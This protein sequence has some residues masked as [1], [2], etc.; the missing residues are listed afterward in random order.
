MTIGTRTGTALLTGLLAATLAACG[1]D[2]GGESNDFADQSIDKIKEQVLADMHDAK[3]LTLKGS[4]SSDS[5]E[6]SLELSADT[7]GNCTGSVSAGEGTADFI[8]A[9]DA[10]FIKADEAFWR[11][12]AGASADAVLKVIGEKWAKLPAGVNQ[13]AE[14]C[15]RDTFIKE[16]EDDNE[17]DEKA[18]KGD[19]TEVDGQQALEI[20]SDED[21]DTTH[22]WVATEGK[23]YI[24]KLESE[25]D[26]PGEFTFNDYDEPVDAK[27]PA[28]GEFVD[29][30]QA[31]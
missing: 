22:A 25:G 24:L 18:E 17:G 10:T 6:T 13:F 7:D 28:D 11:A 30:N 12:N 9:G 27:A 3:S 21:G 2:G 19:E 4:F 20:I 8:K 5:Q 14:F 1:S 23:H 26:E 16:L 29:L 15:D 31:S